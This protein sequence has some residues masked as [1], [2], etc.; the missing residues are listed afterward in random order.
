MK[1]LALLA[2]LAMFVVGC[3]KESDPILGV[4]A[5]VDYQCYINGHQTLA[6]TDVKTWTFK[7]GHV[8]YINSNTPIEHNTNGV[9]LTLTYV[10]SGKSMTYEIQELT[11]N[12]LQVYW[13][14]PKIYIKP[15][16]YLDG[17]D[18]I[19]IFKKME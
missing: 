3:Q 11:D 18:N 16:D 17:S 9:F 15:G 5:L 10:K 12:M 13:N 6:S 7:E 14:K 8:G 2:I 19:Y 4:W 1:R